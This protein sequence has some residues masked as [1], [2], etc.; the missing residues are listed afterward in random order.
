[1]TYFFDSPIG[2]LELS[3]SKS[4]LKRI[5]FYKNKPDDRE[6]E[7]NSIIEQTIRELSEY[8]KG[9]RT[10]FSVPVNAEGTKFQQA[11]WRLLRNI[12]YGKTINSGELAQKMGDPNKVRAV[13]K[14]N[15]QNPVPIIIPCH[16]VIG[17]NNNLVGYAGG[18]SRKKYL[19]K[20]EGALLL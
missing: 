20:H 11:V 1:M 17:A 18:I 12:P 10:H 7:S 9:M 5:R 15:G 14:A 4:A 3:A 19:L 13:G 8:F 16:R 2:W 6:N